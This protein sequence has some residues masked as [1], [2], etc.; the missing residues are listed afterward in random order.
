MHFG[1]HLRVDHPAPAAGSVRPISV[2]VTSER[3]AKHN[4]IARLGCTTLL[5]PYISFPHSSPSALS[6]ET[7]I[8]L[9]WAVGWAVEF[10]LRLRSQAMVGR[11]GRSKGCSTCKKRH[12]KCGQYWRWFFRWSCTNALRRGETDMFALST[13]WPSV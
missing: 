7:I 5:P 8:F 3:Q 2:D 11:R 10:N 1:G 12:L 6:T 4:Y 9:D 13:K